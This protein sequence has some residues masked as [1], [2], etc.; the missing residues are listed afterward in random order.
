MR[1][2][3]EH[4]EPSFGQMLRAARLE[5][6]LDLD[7]VAKETKISM[8][9]LALVE[10][11]N[12]DRLPAEVFVRGFLKAY[13]RCVGVDPAQVLESYTASLEVHRK[14]L[15]YQQTPRRSGR[16][17]WPRVTA[18]LAALFVIIAVTVWVVNRQTP[19]D[20]PS[21]PVKRSVAPA[22][23]PVPDPAPRLAPAAAPTGVQTLKVTAHRQTWLKIIIDGGSPRKVRLNPGDHVELEG[24]R[25]FN[26]LL[27][28][29]H[30]VRI[31]LNDKPVHVPGDDG[32]MVNLE[33]P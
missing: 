30:A 27:E 9:T 14:S 13:A 25:G 5:A 8:H 6:E 1:H 3:S 18:S 10:Q 31:L 22:P 7:E 24:R 19:P 23:G 20:T 4:S 26:L 12:H 15:R 17:L 29:A 33:I 28:N 32:Q 21:P 2:E 16:R 11:E